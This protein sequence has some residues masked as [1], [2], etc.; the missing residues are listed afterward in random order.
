MEKMERNYLLYSC[1]IFL[2]FLF[3][4]AD[5]EYYF[6]GGHVAAPLFEFLFL[7]VCF[8]SAIAGFALTFGAKGRKPVFWKLLVATLM[9]CGYIYILYWG[10]GN[11]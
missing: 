9:P 4:W 11:Y 7:V 3:F 10:S 2:A 5:W 6:I 8:L 1:I